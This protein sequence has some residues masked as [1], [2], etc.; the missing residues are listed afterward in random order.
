MTAYPK[1]F[2]DWVDKKNQQ[3]T[4]VDSNTKGYGGKTD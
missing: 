1:K 2:M 4:L 3:Q